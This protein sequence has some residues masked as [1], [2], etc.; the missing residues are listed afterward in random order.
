MD[1]SVIICT[2]NR[3][4]NLDKTLHSF[5]QQKGLGDCVYEVIVVD[6]NSK[7]QTKEVVKN[8]YSKFNGRLQYVFEP[9]QGLSWARNCGV[10]HAKG[11]LIAFTDDDVI[12]GHE[13]LCGIMKFSRENYFEA[14]G[15]RIVPVYAE[16][17]P[18]WVKDNMDILRGPILIYDYGEDNRVYDPEEML[19]FF[20]ANMVIRKEVFSKYGLFNVELGYGRGT[21]GGDTEFI[22]RLIKDNRALYYC[23][24]IFLW[25]PVENKRMTLMYIAKWF[26]GRSEER[27]V[28]KEC[29]SRW[30]PYH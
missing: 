19:P 15:G 11:E 22:N 29:R 1:I 24:E 7:D 4:E 9:K 27:R 26:I 28:G 13:W 30:S 6:N 23:G 14:I 8:L 10:E 25:H 12:L 5:L 2:C 17:T 21:C 18:A 16:R 3:C 20:G